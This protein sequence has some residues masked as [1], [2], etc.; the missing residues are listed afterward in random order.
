MKLQVEEVRVE[1]GQIHFA[2][3]AA[4]KPFKTDI[5]DLLVVLRKFALP[6][7]DPAT[8]EVAFGTKFGESF[9]HAATL[10]VSPLNVDGSLELNGVKPKNYSP[11]YAHSG[12]LRR[13][14]RHAEPV[15]AVSRGAGW[16][17]RLGATIS[18]LEASLSKLR[19]R[20]R[21]A[22]EDFLSVPAVRRE[23]RGRGLGEAHRSGGRAVEQAGDG[24]VWCARRTGRS[25][26]LGSPRKEQA[27]KALR[28][29]RPRRRKSQ[30][31]D[32][33]VAGEEDRARPLRGELRGPGAGAAGHSSGGADQAQRGQSVQPPRLEGQGGPS[34]GHQQDRQGA[35]VRTG[36]NQSAGSGSERRR[37][38]RGPGSAATLPRGEAQ[39]PGDQRRGHGARKVGA[40]GA[41][42]GPHGPSSSRAMWGSTTSPP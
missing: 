35:R 2:D 3:D 15:H 22:K 30:R 40:Y 17:K 1:Q 32:V 28:P 27:P 9:K 7:V 4:P 34:H 11:Y 10:L 29:R 25:T 18:G 42:T 26:S 20:K 5:E 36:R 31:R 37:A 12:P 13:R 21:G 41:G 19:L 6:Q 23:R 14:G 33:A 8:L 38:E 24:C 16:A 39:H